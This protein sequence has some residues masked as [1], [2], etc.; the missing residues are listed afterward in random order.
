MP[1]FLANQAYTKYY[2]K[3]AKIHSNHEISFIVSTK[4]A[5]RYAA[6]LPARSQSPLLDTSPHVSDNISYPHAKQSYV[7]STLG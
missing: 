5:Y 3:F 4:L 1:D 6:D 7:N 2:S